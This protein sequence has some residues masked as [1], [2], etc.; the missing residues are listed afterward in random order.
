M[1]TKGTG[2][3]AA[4]AEGVELGRLLRRAARAANQVYRRRVMELQLT[5][6]QAAAI[7]ALVESPGL[8]LSALADALGADQA[9]AS[10]LV[11][12]LVAAGLTQRQTDLAD[13]RRVMLLPTEKAQQLAEGLISARHAAEDR[14]RAVLGPRR[15]AELARL[16]ELLVEGLRHQAQEERGP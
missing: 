15:A 11:D 10:G 1:Q 14:I 16:L 4:A 12:R 6:R 7:L 3:E 5:P 2:P 13:R 8:T 9:T